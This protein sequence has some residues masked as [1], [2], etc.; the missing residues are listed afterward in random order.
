[1]SQLE[2]RTIQVGPWGMNTYAFVCPDSNQSIL[3]DP[4]DDPDKLMTMLGDSQPIA[5]WLTHTHIDH[6]SALDEMRQRLN[7]PLI[8]HSGPHAQGMENLQA[9]QWVN[10]G[11]VVMLATFLSCAWALLNLN[12]GIAFLTEWNRLDDCFTIAA[13]SFL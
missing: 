8:A 5:I 13:F 10:D 1:M 4:G 3:F 2:L 12:R 7:V 11:D 9:D 6:V